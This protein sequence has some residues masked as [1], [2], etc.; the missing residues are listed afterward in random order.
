MRSFGPDFFNAIANHP[1]VKPWMGFHSS[2]TIDYTFIVDNAANYC[3][4][5]PC[6]TGG[7]MLVNQGQGHYVAHTLAM[8]SARGK[9]M[10]RLMQEAFQFMFLETDCIEISTMVPDQNVPAL[11][12]AELA[13]FRPTF[14]RE[15]HPLCLIDDLPSNCQFFIQTY[16][17]WVERSIPAKQE[18]HAFHE[19]LEAHLGHENH[20][21]DL[22]HDRYV[23]AAVL[24][25]KAGNPLKAISRYNRWAKLAGYEPAT[26]LNLTP[27]LLNIG[28]GVLQLS[29]QDIEV[30][31]I[32]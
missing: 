9:P 10:Y 29:G 25:C 21:E 15:Q 6:K 27:L 4:L 18:G 31:K 1:E 32:L 20:P 23:G 17:D 16:E 13:R 8:P 2:V 24:G 11:K 5:T 7:Y 3:F 26:I 22:V 19:L 12:W 14:R 30:L 28:S